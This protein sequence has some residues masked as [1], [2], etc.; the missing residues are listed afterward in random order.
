VHMTGSAAAHDAIVFGG[1]AKTPDRTPVLTKPMSSE[2]GGVSPTI[3]VPGKWSAADLRF[4]AQH[5]A[6]QRLHNSG[7]NCVASQ[8]A[9]VSSDW[10][11]K[12]QFLAELE[13]AMDQAPAR[14]A[15]YPGSD[16][17]VARVRAHYPDAKPLGPSG[18]R[19]LLLD[20]PA[21]AGEQA[22]TEEF[23]APV[24]GVTELPGQAADFLRS[25]VHLANSSFAG[26]LGVNIIVDPATVRRLGPVM[27]SAIADLRYGTV[28]VNAWTGVGYLTARASWGAFPGHTLDDVQSG[29]GVVHNALLLDDTERTVVRGPFR[30]MPRSFRHGQFSL[31]PKPPW[32]INNRTAATTGRLLTTFAGTPGWAKLPAIFASALRG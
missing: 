32:F 4:Q 24:L 31:A 27:D 3:V 18:A 12:E 21:V 29:I 13:R 16:D 6:T 28:A 2:L 17:R 15:Y 1:Q 10:P 23:F 22:L 19:T 9:V 5:L 20:V 25:A 30:P 11:Q 7:F 14:E 8:V 26:T